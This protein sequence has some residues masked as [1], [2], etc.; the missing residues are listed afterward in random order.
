MSNESDLIN[1]WSE[2]E[3]SKLK[4][5]KHQS[6]VQSIIDV[7]DGLKLYDNLPPISVELHVTDCCNLVCPWCTDKGQHKIGATLPKEMILDLFSQFS[8]LGTGVTIEGG[9]E[10]TVHRDFAEFVNVGYK[11]HVDLGLITNGTNSISNVINCLKWVRISLDSSTEEEYIVEKGRDMFASVMNNITEYSKIRNREKCY[12]GVG[13]VLTTRNCSRIE[14]IVKRLNDLGVDY[15]YFRP[16][17]EAPDITPSREELYELKNRLLNLTETMRIKFIFKIN[18]R[19]IKDNAGL[20][21]VAHGLTSIIHADGNVSL[22]EKRRHDGIII[23]NLYETDFEGIWNSKKRIEATKKLLD[24]RN[25]IG[26]E[27]CRITPFNCII[28]D[29]D[30]MNTE[31]FI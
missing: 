4:L 15:I 11:N 14:E 3:Y 1:Y 31:S 24:A 5:L 25:Q 2:F 30:K 7:Y 17:E 8:R 28:S 21:C 23:G 13:Y 16:V 6:K 12:L 20:P 26:C 27:V 9:G 22:C 18:D 10:P 29:L 19:L